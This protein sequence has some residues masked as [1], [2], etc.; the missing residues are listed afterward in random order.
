MNTRFS[1]D[2]LS[3]TLVVQTASY[4]NQDKINKYL[5]QIAFAIIPMI[6]LVETA[7]ALTFTALSLIA[8]PCSSKPLEF[9]VKW[10]KSSSFAIIWSLVNFCIN[11]LSKFLLC[12][13]LIVS[14]QEAR[15]MLQNRQLIRFD[16]LDDSFEDDLEES[17]P[18]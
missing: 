1:T 2:S 11:P 16:G 17:E 4:Q 5:S 18:A 10:L 9:S 12:E 7:A 15:Q 14:E 6:A 3:T 13:R 8:Y